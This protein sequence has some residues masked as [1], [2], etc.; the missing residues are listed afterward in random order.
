MWFK[1]FPKNLVLILRI[2]GTAIL[3]ISVSVSERGRSASIDWNIIAFRLAASIS[4]P[5]NALDTI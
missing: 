3:N 1:T 4:C 5:T 2:P